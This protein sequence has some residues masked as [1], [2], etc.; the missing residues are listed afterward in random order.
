MEYAPLKYMLETECG[1]V[2]NVV[3]VM[4]VFHFC[5]IFCMSVCMPKINSSHSQTTNE[6]K[7]SN[8]IFITS[9]VKHFRTSSV[10]NKGI[11][12]NLDVRY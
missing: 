4:S 11:I 6:F 10:P 9:L 8:K 3:M 2:M 12:H 1:H 5:S 7:N